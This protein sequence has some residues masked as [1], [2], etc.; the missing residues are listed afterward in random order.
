MTDFQ[1]MN[2]EAKKENYINGIQNQRNKFD[3]NKTEFG[4][5]TAGLDGTNSTDEMRGSQSRPKI[6]KRNNSPSTHDSVKTI[7]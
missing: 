2:P 3:D 4:F 5:E 6:G 1:I 7:E